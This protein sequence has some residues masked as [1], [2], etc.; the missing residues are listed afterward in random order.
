MRKIFFAVIAAVPVLMLYSPESQASH[1]RHGGYG[2]HFGMSVWVGPGLWWPYYPNYSYYPA[3]AARVEEQPD[4]NLQERE[5]ESYWYY[6]PDP[7]GYYPYVR[8]CPQGWMKVVPNP[9]PVG[10]EE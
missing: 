4:L 9:A 1:G 7:R 2:G 3:P 10:P 6:C 8:K 5:E